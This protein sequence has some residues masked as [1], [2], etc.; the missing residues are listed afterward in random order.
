MSVYNRN[1]HRELDSDRS[2]AAEIINAI[3]DKV[4]CHIMYLDGT[5]V[6]PF[7]RVLFSPLNASAT[8]KD[9]WGKEILKMWTSLNDMEI[10]ST[11]YAMTAEVEP[12]QLGV[13]MYL[14]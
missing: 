10:Y 5:N 8:I 13:N 11:V 1:M 12:R 9:F 14:Y 3:S 4:T 7:M 6:I 2:V